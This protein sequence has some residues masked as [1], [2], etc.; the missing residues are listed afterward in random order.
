MTE[1][2]FDCLNW[3]IHVDEKCRNASV[4]R[5]FCWC[6]Q[7]IPSSTTW[8][9]AKSSVSVSPAALWAQWWK[10]CGSHSSRLRQ[11]L[12]WRGSGIPEPASFP[13]GSWLWWKNRNLQSAQTAL[14]CLWRKSPC[15][16]SNEPGWGARSGYDSIHS[17]PG[18]WQSA[19]K[20]N[21]NIGTSFSHASDTPQVPAKKR[22]KA[23][24][25]RL[26][27]CFL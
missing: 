16:F 23:C 10:I 9:W 27:A 15:A 5:S 12:F 18:G 26:S 20:Q 3:E 7:K 13:A 1:L 24:L 25:K 21:W 17:I 8:S 6:L 19:G 22:A 4:F 2:R 11:W 14:S